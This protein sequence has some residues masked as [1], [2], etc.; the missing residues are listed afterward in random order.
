MYI[1][2]NASFS[3]LWTFFLVLTLLQ[4]QGIVYESKKSQQSLG[5]TRVCTNAEKVRLKQKAGRM[6]LCL[7]M[8]FPSILN[9]KSLTSR[10][11]YI[12]RANIMYWL[13]PTSSVM[14]Q[15][16]KS[17]TYNEITTKKDTHRHT[18]AHTH[19]LPSWQIT[20]N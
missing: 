7:A 13:S 11:C 8:S 5:R 19:P 6:C 12:K 18:Q 16:E 1:F 15:E 20:E 3:Q 17:S 10:D 4:F 9:H 2:C 14:N